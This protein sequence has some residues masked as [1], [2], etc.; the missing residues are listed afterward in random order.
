MIS[1]VGKV[2]AGLDRLRSGGEVGNDLV[3]TASESEN[4]DVLIKRGKNGFRAEGRSRTIR[5]NPGTKYGGLDVNGGTE[6]PSFIGLGHELAHYVDGLDGSVDNNVWFNIG[7]KPIRNIEKF[8]MHV[9]NALRQENGLALRAWY[10]K[11]AGEGRALNN[12]GNSAWYQTTFTVRPLQL[13]SGGSEDMA[14]QIQIPFNYR[15]HKMRF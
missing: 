6:R 2:Q 13:S 8:A 10:G 7:S 1:Y 4:D 11:N 9:E 14:R 12:N 3:E 15:L 5:W